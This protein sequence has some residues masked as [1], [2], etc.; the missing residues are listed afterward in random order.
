MLR[1]RMCNHLITV[2]CNYAS[3]MKRLIVIMSES[4]R[5]LF[6]TG[7]LFLTNEESER[8]YYTRADSTR[9]DIQFSSELIFKALPTHR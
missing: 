5:K 7:L 9:S 2:K 6:C 8:T 4:R 1:G 3:R